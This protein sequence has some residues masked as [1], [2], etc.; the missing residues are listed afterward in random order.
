MNNATISDN[1]ETLARDEGQVVDGVGQ[2]NESQQNEN[3]SEN[4]EEQAKYFQSEKDKLYAENKNL[5]QYEELGKFL[6]SRP[7]ITDKISEMVKGGG[8]PT[9]P[10]IELSKDEFDPW[11]AY[12]D[13][14]SKSFK[15]REQELQ[16]RIAGAVNDSMRGIN[17]KMGQTQLE[18]ELKTRG[19]NDDQ[20][21]SFFDFASKNPAQYGVDGA[22]KMWQAVTGQSKS[23]GNPLDAVRNNQSQPQSGGV[24]QGH[25]P[26]KTS[27]SDEMWKGILAKAKNNSG[28]LP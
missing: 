21:K 6:E 9:K 7:D 25:A 19:L 15:Y 10:R 26:A 5:K 8:E 18:S 27:D 1:L 20:V 13:P 2:N 16:D 14:N 12:N 4:W 3:S 28:M 11:E 24:L 17:Q 23:E 22:I